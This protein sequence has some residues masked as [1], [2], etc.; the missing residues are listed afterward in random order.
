[1]TTFKAE[2]PENY[3]QKCCCCLVVDVSGSMSGAP[4]NELNDGIQ[5]FYRDIQGDPTMADRLEMAVVEFSD[6]VTTL[7][8]PSLVTNFTM[9]TL[10]TKGLTDLVGGVLS[11]V[12]LKTKCE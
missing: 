7:V 11:L 8:D 2:S 10:T 3:Q 1:M 9:P 12:P 5:A 6:R 4:I